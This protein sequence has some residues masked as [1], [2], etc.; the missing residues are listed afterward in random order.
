VNVIRDDVE[1]IKD[2]RWQRTK[3]RPFV[4]DMLKEEWTDCGKNIT[5]ELSRATLEFANEIPCLLHIYKDLMPVL[6]LWD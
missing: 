1:K 6:T 5:K 3:T 2:L 4:P